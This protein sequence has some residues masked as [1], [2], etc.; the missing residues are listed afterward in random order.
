MKTQMTL[1]PFRGTGPALNDLLGGQVDLICDQP[2]STAGHLSA[3]TIK[4]V[5]VANAERLPTLPDVPTFAESGLDN[6]RLYVWHGL[7]APKGTPAPVVEKLA[8]ALRQALAD[9]A[10]RER[11]TKLG[12]APADEARATPKALGE[13]L[14]K[15]IARWTPIIRATGL[16]AD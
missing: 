3:G 12:A 15:D 5:A 11:M 7:Y 4:P 10:L 13:F 1:V 9:P 6:F 2:A 14:A 16:H 8:S